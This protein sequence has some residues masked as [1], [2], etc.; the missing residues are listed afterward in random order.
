MDNLTI[1]GYVGS[2]AQEYAKANGFQFSIVEA[3]PLSYLSIALASKEISVYQPL[4]FI[5]G[6][7]GGAFNLFTFSVIQDD[8]VIMKSEETNSSEFV[9]SPQSE[10]DYQ[11][12]A[13]VRSGEDELSAATDV[14]TVKE[15]NVDKLFR[16][17]LSGTTATITKYIGKSESI[18]VPESIKGKNV[19][20]I[21]SKAFSNNET[22]KQVILPDTVKIIQKNAFS[23]CPSLQSVNIPTS[24]IEVG[25]S[26]FLDC[27]L[28]GQLVF[29]DTME[30]IGQSAFLGCGRISSVQLPAGLAEIGEDA[31]APGTYFF[32]NEAS[33]AYLYAK[34]NYHPI[35]FEPIDLDMSGLETADQITDWVIE[36]Y[37]SS[38]MDEFEKA[39][40]LHDWLIGY[41]EYDGEAFGVIDTTYGKSMAEQLLQY[42][43]GVCR[44]YASAYQVLLRKAG[45][46][47]EYVRGTTYGG[48]GGHAW[49][50]VRM[51]GDWYHVDCTWDDPNWGECRAYFGLSDEAISITHYG[52]ST[53]SVCEAYKDNFIYRTGALENPLEKA[54]EDIEANLKNGKTSFVITISL[55]DTENKRN[56][57]GQTAVLALNDMDWSAYDAED[58]L[59][60]SCV[61]WSEKSIKVKGAFMAKRINVIGDDAVLGGKRI[62]L[63][64]D[65]LP[66]TTARKAVSWLSSNPD[67]ATISAEGMVS[68]KKVTETT[69][70]TITAT[71]KDGS[72]VI[73]EKVITVTPETQTVSL[74]VDDVECSGETLAID[75]ASDVNSLA[76]N[77]ILTPADALQEVAW[78]TSDKTIA[79]VSDDGLVTGLKRGTVTITATAADGTRVMN[80]CKVSVTSL[81]K[82]IN[83]TGDN[84]IISGKRTT[85]DVEVLPKETPNR[86][87]TWES[88]DEE[89]A[90]I[91]SE[92]RVT[93]KPVD[94]TKTVTFTA[95]A[96]DGSG[97]AAE[98]LITVIPAVQEV[99]VLQK[100]AVCTSE[101]LIIDLLSDTDTL[102]LAAAVSPVQADQVITWKSSDKSIAT[103]SEDG[104]VTGLTKGAVTI[105]ATSTSGKTSDGTS[106]KASCKVKVTNLAKEIII[107]GE[108]MVTSGSST[109]LI[110]EVS[111]KETLNKKVTWEISDEAIAT[112]SSEGRVTTKQVTETKTA[113]IT[114]TAKDGSGVS[115]EWEIA[116]TPVK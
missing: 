82:E 6:A 85:L 95:T 59:S 10:G 23:N 86:K 74:L 47:Y 107:S 61:E 78:R 30:R 22:L 36:N 31:F 58:Q 89:I 113:T 17:S 57:V 96:Q 32:V 53:E 76:L 71:A 34:A 45:I 101:T 110:A 114:A 15:M 91:N 79:T 105:T 12:I 49:N 9:W 73:G 56:L 70:V 94:E 87:V 16:Y 72:G 109:T 48:S 29:P 20:T 90:T 69:T 106:I 40:V 55:K 63:K 41:S 112:I 24:L 14:F 60:F 19:T 104:M 116:V 4:N 98:W 35:S 43:I 44:H 26:A 92:G 42:G 100:D 7:T 115:A 68:V 75:M 64:V 67:I 103:V 54:K 81:A 8:I 108:N 65:V 50:L 39:L 111:P 1:E 21:A 97:I 102:Q 27:D 62:T 51:E 13:S 28:T 46:K 84:I 33:Y 52:Y 83:I 5:C 11:V 66:E 2:S 37:I 99:S 38:D 3:P 80:S 25:D 77:V 88:S 18:L 93:A